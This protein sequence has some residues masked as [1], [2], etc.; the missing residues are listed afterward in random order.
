MAD[1]MFLN[2]KPEMERVVERL[3]SRYGYQNKS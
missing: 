1:D 3:R 2:K